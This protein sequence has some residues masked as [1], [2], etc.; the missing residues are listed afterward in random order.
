MYRNQARSDNPP[1]VFAVADGSYHAMLHQRRSQCIVISGESGS[2][3]KCVV[4]HTSQF[5]YIDKVKKFFWHNWL[6][7]LGKT[8]TA[9]L[10]LKQLVTL[11]KVTAVSKEK[12]CFWRLQLLFSIRPPTETWRRKFWWWTRLW[13]HSA[14]LR[15]A[16]TTTHRVLQSTLTWLSRPAAWFLGHACLFTYSNTLEWSIKLSMSYILSFVWNALFIFV[17]L[18]SNEKNFHIFYYLCEGLAAESKLKQYYFETGKRS[19]RYLSLPP[20]NSSQRQ[21]INVLPYCH[22]TR[23]RSTCHVRYRPTWRNSNWYAKV[24]SSWILPRTKWMQFTPFWQP[25]SI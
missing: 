14:T 17:A 25:S 13:K 8:V 19:H 2:G 15:R 10:L 5:Y 18:L 23:F 9:N 20:L 12:F 24:F 3:E 16:S 1:H 11:G 7:F 4:C 21:V 6:N 22:E